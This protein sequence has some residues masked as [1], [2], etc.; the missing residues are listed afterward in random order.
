MD[1]LRLLQDLDVSNKTVIVRVDLNV[2]VLNG[3]IVDDIRLKKIL[4]TLEYLLLRNAKIVLISHFGRPK[5]KFVSEMSLKFLVHPLSEMLQGKKVHFVEN[6]I[7]KE[8]EQFINS[9][10]NGDIILMENLRFYP[11]ET[12]NEA[13][14]VEKLARLGQIYINDSFSCSHREH[15]SIVGL[16]QKLPSAAGLLLH[17]EI[18]NLQ[19]FWKNA[20]TPIMAVVGG[21]KISTKLELLYQL[22]EKVN[23][24]VIGGAM[25]N[26]F[27]KAEGLN[28]GKSLYEEN[29]LEEARNIVFKANKLGCNLILPID[30]VIAD[31]IDLGHTSRMVDVEYVDNNSV[32]A[33]LG[34]KTVEMIKTQIK[35]AKSLVWNGPLG[36][37]EYPPFEQATVMV[38]K[39][40]VQATTDSNLLS[41]A[42]GGDILAALKNEKLAEGFSYISTG[43]GAFLE[44]LQGDKLPGIEVLYNNVC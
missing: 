4:P 1:N 29:L 26:S 11:G 8:A 32:I 20:H 35:Y 41:L 27:L 24:L 14:F 23:I 18:K 13:N 28:I 40:V 30:V 2:P 6:Y 33:D 15:A 42:G 12:S 38:A 44:W 5:G 39:E 17:E 31:S 37:F 7:E 16:A 19:S 36:A 21:A 9:C 3:K 43:G 10:Q 34:P 22:L 25:A